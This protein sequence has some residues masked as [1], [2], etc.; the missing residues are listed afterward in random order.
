MDF[1]FEIFLRGLIANILGLYS[2]YLF[3]ILIGRK[4]TI[5]YLSG[6]T[7]DERNNIGQN[8]LNTAVGLI[9]ALL[10]ALSVLFVLNHI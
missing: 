6:E 5:R 7:K 3:F 10:I 8:F 9:A 1:I 4:K 2:R